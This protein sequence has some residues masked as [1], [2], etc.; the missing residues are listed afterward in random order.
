[1]LR[2]KIGQKE[3]WRNPEIRIQTSDTEQVFVQ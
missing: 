2:Q 3:D 1:M